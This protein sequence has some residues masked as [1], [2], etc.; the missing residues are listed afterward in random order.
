MAEFHRRKNAR[1]DIVWLV[2]VYIGKDAN[3]K[4]IIKNETVHSPNRKDAEAAVR[5]ILAERDKGQLIVNR[6]TVNS[7]LDDLLRD[8]R[9]NGK[10]LEWATRVCRKH[11]RPYFGAM[12]ID[13][14]S[15]ADIQKFIAKRQAE[16]A[17]SGT[18]NTSLALLR[19][20]FNL[21]HQCTPAKC[22]KVPY[23]PMLKLDNVRKGFFEDEEYRR[24][25]E[26]LPE[27]LRPILAFGY[28]TGCRKG[29]ILSLRWSQVDLEQGMVR[30]E[31][32]TTKN[33]QGRNIPLVPEL[34]E[35]LRIRRVIRDE[36]WPDCDHVFFRFGKPILQFKDAWAAACRKAGLWD[37]TTRRPTRLFHDLR[38]S[39]VRNLIR[40]GVPEVVAM[41]ISGHRTRSIFDRY[42][43]VDERDLKDAAWKLSEFLGRK[44][45]EQARAITPT[46]TPTKATM[47]TIQ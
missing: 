19:R 45:K 25:F 44:Q 17:A 15:T 37:E 18:I 27:D 26:A 4:A 21:G 32:G 2:R 43:I 31:P 23:F 41:Q 38:R 40:S 5:R 35:L 22:G 46:N 42:N 3:G 6:E 10:D 39:G 34:L 7:L 14:V 29:E 47:E 24:L 36:H 20:A 8:Y 13:K 30:L 9:I 16:G 12:R 28:Y 11:L 33:K 1:G